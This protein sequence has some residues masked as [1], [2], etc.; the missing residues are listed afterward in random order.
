MGIRGT[1]QNQELFVTLRVPFARNQ[2]YVEGRATL[3]DA[4][5][6]AVRSAESA[7]ALGR[8]RARISSHAVAALR[9][10]YDLSG[11]DT[12]RPGGD[13]HRN[14]VGIRIVTAKPMKLG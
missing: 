8:H 4:E 12:N 6:L 9:G 13:R 14:I 7:L 2:A 1:F 11:Q 10:V 5:A 3:L